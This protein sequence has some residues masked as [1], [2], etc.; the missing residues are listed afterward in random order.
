MA[1]LLQAINIHFAYGDRPALRGISLSVSAGQTIA[2]IGPN[3]SGKSTLIQSLLGHL[4]ATGSITLDGRPIT[5]IPRREF[6]R[7]VAY[8]AQSPS[9]EPGQTVLD[10]LR[11]GRAP[12]WAAFGLESP[13]DA[14]VVRDI[15]AQLSL[16]DLLDRPMEQLSGGQRQRVFIGRCLVQQPTLLL[17]DEPDT[18]LDLRYQVELAKLIRALAT[19]TRIGVLWASH[20]LNHAAAFRR[21]T[22]PVKERNRSPRREV[23][24]KFCDRICSAMCITSRSNASN[25][26][27]ERQSSSR[28]EEENESARLSRICT[29][30]MSRFYS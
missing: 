15:S 5:G 11:V 12:Y 1:E 16:D 6:A 22:R 3:G 20:D 13:G 25:A 28:A 21:P 2:L 29:K 8:L 24:P 9:F 18:Y 19:D 7:H 10:V 30:K 26:P 4:R 23:R 17:L 27:V 14:A